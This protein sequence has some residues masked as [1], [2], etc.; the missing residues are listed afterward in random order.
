MIIQPNFKPNS[1]DKK[2]I[3]RYPFKSNTATELNKPVQNNHHLGR[4][5]GIFVGA[6]AVSFGAFK[7][8]KHIIN[9]PP[10][11]VVELLEDKLAQITI[12]KD[13]AL[14][15]FSSQLNNSKKELLDVFSRP[16]LSKEELSNFEKQIQKTQNKEELLNVEES[17][18]N[19]LSKWV[20]K[21]LNSG[22]K[23]PEELIK[24]YSETSKKLKQQTSETEQNAL[25]QIKTHS[26]IPKDIQSK[27]RAKKILQSFEFQN[28]EAQR[29]IKESKDATE[30]KLK[31]ETKSLFREY[32]NYSK[33]VVSN[34]NN[35]A[36]NIL[37]LVSKKLET[38]VNSSITIT[39]KSHASVNMNLIPASMPSSL[40]NNKFYQFASN[41]TEKNS[42][43]LIPEFVSEMGEELSLKDIKVLVKRL[44]L[45]QKTH[46]DA[47]SLSWYDAKIQQ[48]KNS[49]SKV[50]AYLENSF[51]NSGKNIDVNNLSE[52]QEE[53][54]IFSL[55]EHAKKMGFDSIESMNFHFAAGDVSDD[56]NLSN[57]VSNRMEKYS[58]STISK[59]YPKI[60]DKLDDFSRLVDNRM[61]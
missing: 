29:I 59:I 42:E 50:S 49:E 1:Y 17:C 21:N 28:E 22:K 15:K 31:E 18:F 12:V 7:G 24:N 3:V 34:K 51:Y 10:K 14:E 23:S 16:I 53:S 40:L 39:K 52:K 44:E 56:G 47:N 46:A 27:R 30:T 38:L 37:S 61:N 55:Q 54:I 48:L 60:K 41:V 19:N 4:N 11:Q 9:K 26:E 43:K 33:K 13:Q 58:Q 6:V 35:T 20:D 45:R 32:N 25:E 2:S 57:N 36:Q 8:I 5:L